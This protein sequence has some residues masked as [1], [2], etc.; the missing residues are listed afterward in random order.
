MAD[1]RLG[2]WFGE[3]LGVQVMEPGWAEGRPWTGG[4]LKTTTATGTM[5]PWCDRRRRPHFGRRPLWSTHDGLELIV[6]FGP[7]LTER[8][9][10]HLKGISKVETDDIDDSSVDGRCMARLDSVTVGPTS[11]NVARITVRGLSSRV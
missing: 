10:G 6:S 7:N 5:T 2:F 1:E 11:R 3:L 9:S 4:D 8:C